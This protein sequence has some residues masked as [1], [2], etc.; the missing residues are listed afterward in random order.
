M[1][2]ENLRRRRGGS[3]LVPDG[4]VIAGDWVIF[5]VSRG[6]QASGRKAVAQNEKT[7]QF[8]GAGGREFPIRRHLR[9][10]DGNVVGVTFDSQTADTERQDGSD[11]IESGE[12]RSL[13]G[14][15]S[16]VEKAE[17][18]QTNDEPLGLAV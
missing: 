8:G 5:G 2:A 16:T 3:G 13:Q 17:L 10:M 1:F 6:R 15:G 14:C 7:D 11:V 4:G 18:A 9:S 12:G